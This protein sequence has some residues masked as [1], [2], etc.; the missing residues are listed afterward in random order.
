M[1]GCVAMPGSR[2]WIGLGASGGVG[3]ARPALQSWT[4]PHSPPHTLKLVPPRASL[5]QERGRVG[6]GRG[7]GY[8]E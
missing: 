1:P 8:E 4:P 6:G 7:G 5:C 3:E 2:A